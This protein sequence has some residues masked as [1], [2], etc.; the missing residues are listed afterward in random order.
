LS[1][2]GE[3]RGGLATKKRGKVRGG[4]RK[5]NRQGLRK[6]KA[7]NFSV[8]KEDVI[9]TRGRN[10]NLLKSGKRF[11]RGGTNPINVHGRMGSHSKS[12]DR[13]IDYVPSSSGFQG[14]VLVLG[15]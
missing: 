15:W 14:M 7:G 5:T 13:V 4:V 8:I 9:Q 2:E 6:T 11:G 1:R 3:G 10:A 12:E